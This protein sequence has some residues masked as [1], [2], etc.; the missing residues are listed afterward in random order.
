M[1]PHLPQLAVSFCR[2]NPLSATPSQSSARPLHSSG[3]ITHASGRASG[4]SVPLVSPTVPPPPLLPPT[5]SSPWPPP[6]C[7]P[8]PVSGNSVST[9]L[10]TLQPLQSSSAANARARVIARTR[11][12]GA[13][14]RTRP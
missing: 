4:L 8:V 7:P 11:R 6:P 3:A 5:S 13:A 1:L 14:A 9:T 2:S 12:D 10:R